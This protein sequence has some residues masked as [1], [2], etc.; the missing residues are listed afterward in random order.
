M[1]RTVIAD[2]FRELDRQL[3]GFSPGYQ[4]RQSVGPD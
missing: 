1:L 2:Q 4:Y 3:V